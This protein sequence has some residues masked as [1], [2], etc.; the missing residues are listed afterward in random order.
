MDVDLSPSMKDYL[1]TILLLDEEEPGCEGIL[2]A[3]CPF[4][5]PAVTAALKSLKKSRL[6]GIRKKFLHR[7]NA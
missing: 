1:E 4:Q 7:P 6:G 2:P 3:R 5:M